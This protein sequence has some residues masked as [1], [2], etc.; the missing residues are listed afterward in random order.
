LRLV[1]RFFPNRRSA[2]P[3]FTELLGQP[4]ALAAPADLRT[5][6]VEVLRRERSATEAERLRAARADEEG[7]L[8][9]EIVDGVATIRIQ[10]LLIPSGAAQWRY[11]GGRATDY[12]EITA[13]AVAAT[14]DANVRAAMLDIDSIGGF[15][16]G[17]SPAVDAL[18]ELRQKKPLHSHTGGTMASCAYHLGS[19]AHRVTA[20]RNATAGSVGEMI[21]LVDSSKGLKE[22]G[23]EVIVIRSG[24][25]KGAG[26]WGAEIT[27]EQR[28]AFQELVGDGHELFLR[29]VLRGRQDLSR[30]QLTAVA[31]GRSFYA[32]RAMKH[33][34]IDAVETNVQA[35]T[36]CVTARLEDVAPSTVDED[37]AD[38][39]DVETEVEEADHSAGSAGDPTNE[40]APV[41]AGKESDM[42]NAPKPAVAQPPA[43]T[44]PV[45]APTP[46][47]EQSSE[48]EQLRAENA[49]LKAD[50]EKLEARAELERMNAQAERD[51]ALVD[52]VDKHVEAGRVAP[53]D[54]EKTIELAKKGFAGDPTGLD[55]H[56]GR[57]KVVTKPQR[58]SSPTTQQTGAETVVIPAEDR[59]QLQKMAA[60][61]GCSVEDLARM[62]GVENVSALGGL[63]V[64]EGGKSAKASDLLTAKG[65]A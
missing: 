32:E 19:Q 3:S 33:G 58:A 14:N 16:R 48:L 50:H 36:V 18:W 37:E 1:D 43:A 11:W 13:M 55:E 42:S 61:M 56:L 41:G 47:T 44:T 6:F 34:L 9:M 31:D 53:A 62:D 28:A 39:A 60:A 57:L 10:G 45:P 40:P 52:V 29:D 17:I 27:A 22:E 64:L 8:P 7:A 4:C 46:A 65:G 30:R 12:Q 35:M 20:D 59:A 25:H 63:V 51:R 21:V 2:T 24:K 38:D 23:I 5:Q 26:V 54:R 49:R 15:V